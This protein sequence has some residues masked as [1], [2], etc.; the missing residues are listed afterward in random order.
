MR[1]REQFNPNVPWW[2][3]KRCG[4]VVEWEDDDPEPLFVELVKDYASWANRVLQI[5][6]CSTEL[7]DGLTICEVAQ[8]QADASG[9]YDLICACTASLAFTNYGDELSEGGVLL[10]AACAETHYIETQE[11]FGRG[12]GWPPGRPLRF[13]IPDAVAASGLQLIFFAE[14]FGA[15]FCP[16]AQAFIKLLEASSI[17]PGFDAVKDAALIREV[18]RKL[19]SDRG[20]RNTE[21][22]AIYAASKSA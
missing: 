14:Y 12:V 22:L 1:D 16:D 9:E 6:C 4:C 17:I 19:M 5:G 3:S 11:I 10:G 8:G 18:Q 7:M 20:I 21:H 13:A 2:E 15:S